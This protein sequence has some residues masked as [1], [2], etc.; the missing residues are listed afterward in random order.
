MFGGITSSQVG[1]K[2]TGNSLKGRKEI[3]QNDQ[4]MAKLVVTKKTLI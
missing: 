1:L 3:K 4:Y 2:N